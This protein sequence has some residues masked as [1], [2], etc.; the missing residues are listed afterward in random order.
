M[1]CVY[2][3]PVYL[4]SPSILAPAFQT[5]NYHSNDLLPRTHVTLDAT[6]LNHHVGY[7]MAT[8]TKLANSKTATFRLAVA[9]KQ[10]NKKTDL[11]NKVSSI[12]D[13]AVNCTRLFSKSEN[14]LQ[15][16]ARLCASWRMGVWSGCT[17][18]RAR[19]FPVT[20]RACAPQ[21]LA[22]VF[23]SVWTIT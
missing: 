10:T 4:K 19:V 7:F 5:D 22:V 17:L 16:R 9:L 14:K 8:Q 20:S 6:G 21:A 11:F 13:P 1:I 15:P 12:Y 2:L 18:Q 23:F 3:W